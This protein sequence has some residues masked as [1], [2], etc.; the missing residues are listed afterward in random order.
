MNQGNRDFIF[1]FNSP[2]SSV[3]MAVQAN[4]F[5]PFV[6]TTV[7]VYDASFNVLGFTSMN[8]VLNA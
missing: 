4:P 3:G 5:A 6:A 7:T 8:G 2:V 1:S